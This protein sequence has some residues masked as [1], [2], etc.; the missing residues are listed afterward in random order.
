VR[1]PKSF[2]RAV[3]LVLSAESNMSLECQKMMRLL[4]AL[5]SSIGKRKA[6]R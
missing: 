1:K 6:R 2:R 3:L 5:D 4:A